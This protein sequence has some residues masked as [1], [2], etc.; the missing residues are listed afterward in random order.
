M[1]LKEL[2]KLLGLSPTTVSRALNGYPEVN[3]ATRARVAEAALL[4]GYAPNLL[5][6]RLATGRTHSI[7]HVIPLSAHQM[8]NPIFADF[9]AGA[10]EVYSAAGYDMLLSVVPAEQEHQAY[11]RMAAQRGVDGFIVHGPTVDDPRIGLLQDL[12]LPFVVHGRGGASHSGYSW[13]DIN[14]RRGF[15]RATELLLDLGHERIAF[16]NGQET[17]SFAARRRQGFDSAMAARNV[18][19]DPDLVRCE[20]MIEPYGYE[21]ARQ[22]LTLDRPPTAFL[23][24]SIMVAQG[25]LRAVRE[26][27]LEFGRD[28]SILTH[29]DD[30]SF[31]PNHGAIPLF[32]ATRSSIR[33]AGHRTAEILI[34]LMDNP[35]T[36]PRQE[37]W[38]SD[39]MIGRSTGPRR[40]ESGRA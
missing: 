31:L 10:G 9:I 28:I 37:L 20:E 29:D 33:D 32:T 22:M 24:S 13:L 12:G 26:L 7:G 8:I 21:A 5:A 3:A 27:G 38:E 15:L 25:V 11:R 34:E 40:K 19:V 36:G 2:S 18:P 4:H 39:L 35:G 23:V 6:K 14:N 17:M 1:N 16:L 30:L